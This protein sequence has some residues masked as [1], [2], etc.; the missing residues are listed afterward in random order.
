[1]SMA[2]TKSGNANRDPGGWSVGCDA[3]AAIFM[4]NNPW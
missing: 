4:R 3:I 1:L 2:A